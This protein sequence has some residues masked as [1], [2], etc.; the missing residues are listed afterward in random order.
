MT[1]AAS[2]PSYV[3]SGSSVGGGVFCGSA[4]PPCAPDSSVPV[5]A[6]R[7]S[8]GLLPASAGLSTGGIPDWQP[9][10]ARSAPRPDVTPVSLKKRHPFGVASSR[11]LSLVPP[12]Y[13]NPPALS[14]PPA[15][16]FHSMPIRISRATPRRGGSA[17]VQRFVRASPPHQWPVPP[18]AAGPALWGGSLRIPTRLWLTSLPL[19]QRVLTQG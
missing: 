19:F 11:C 13:R 10:H 12:S 9:A 7:A 4:G 15:R 16:P 3:S 14:S 6:D 8:S 17:P 18:C 5:C 1:I 2:A